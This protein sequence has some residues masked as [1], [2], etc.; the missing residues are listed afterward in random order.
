MENQAPHYLSYP[1]LPN[2]YAYT[3]LDESFT[4]QMSDPAP[5]G[6]FELENDCLNQSYFSIHSKNYYLV[7]TLKP[8]NLGH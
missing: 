7:C 8:V 6:Y 4:T 1:V 2:E 5:T 3:M